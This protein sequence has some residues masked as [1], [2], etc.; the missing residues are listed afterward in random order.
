MWLM[1]FGGFEPSKITGETKIRP[2]GIREKKFMPFF[3]R[4]DPRD[5]AAKWKF[6]KSKK[7][8]SPNT[9]LLST[10]RSRAIHRSNR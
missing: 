7:V 5:V 6:Q 1:E 9:P 8:S 10:Y 4:G 3:R 2:R